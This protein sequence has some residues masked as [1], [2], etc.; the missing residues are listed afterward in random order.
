MK[1]SEGRQSY[2]AHRILE[3]FRDEGLLTVDAGYERLALN[4]IKRAFDQD[5]ERDLRVDGLVRRKIDSLS[6]TVLVGSPEW[7]IL[8]RKYYDEELRK[9]K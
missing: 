7:D 6:R 9:L 1:L 2:L 8:Y 4:E 5:H 3:V